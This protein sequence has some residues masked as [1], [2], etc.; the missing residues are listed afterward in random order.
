MSVRRTLVKIIT[1]LGCLVPLAG[2]NVRK[3][4]TLGVAQ[5]GADCKASI[6]ATYG[7]DEGLLGLKIEK[8]SAQPTYFKISFSSYDGFE[9]FKLKM[10]YSEKS[11]RLWVLYQESDERPLLSSYSIETGEFANKY[12]R[13]LNPSTAPDTEY[14]RYRTAEVPPLESDAAEVMN[15]THPGD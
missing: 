15:I 1:L 13:L 5:A 12:G 11:K 8:S 10:Y 14:P 2:C 6:Y 4:S 7:Y 3:G 9:A